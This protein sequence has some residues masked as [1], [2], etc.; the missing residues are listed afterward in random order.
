M[1]SPASSVSNCTAEIYPLQYWKRLEGPIMNEHY[2][3]V[4]ADLRT[5]RSQ[6]QSELQDLES[7]ISAINRLCGDQEIVPSYARIAPVMT[8]SLE[9]RPDA[10]YANISV[11]WAVLWHLAEFA[12]D[13][14]KTGQIANAL[15]AGGYKSD[16]AKFGNM[17]SAVLSNMKAKGEVE[18]VED[19]GYRLSDDGRR[20]WN[21]IR[22]GSKFRAAISSTEHSLLSVQ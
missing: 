19:A 10:R 16:A 6:L 15:L 21:L 3:A 11:R 8:N 22:Q 1:P 20:T 17:V 14:E 18:F 4:L 9:P 7:A 13:Y 5:R 2:A 12:S